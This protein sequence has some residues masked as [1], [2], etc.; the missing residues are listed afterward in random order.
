MIEINSLT[1]TRAAAAHWLE[2]QTTATYLTAA[3]FSS[4]PTAVSSVVVRFAV[5]IETIAR[6]SKQSLR[7]VRI[8]VVW[9]IFFVVFFSEV[10]NRCK[11]FTN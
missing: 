8:Y 2:L 10:Q 1:S 5:V 11:V 6:L 3:S 7:W 4:S 9:I